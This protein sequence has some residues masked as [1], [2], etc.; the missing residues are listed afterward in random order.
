MEK[1]LFW[2]GQHCTYFGTGHFYEY[3]STCA[4]QRTKCICLVE[5]TMEQVIACGLL[6]YGNGF[7]SSVYLAK[8]VVYCVKDFS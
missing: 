6:T 5:D 3:Y 1:L 2:G 7:L 4:A 8:G